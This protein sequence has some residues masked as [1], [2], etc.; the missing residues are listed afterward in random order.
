MYSNLHILSEFFNI[1]SLSFLPQANMWFCLI[2]ILPGIVDNFRIL[3]E[4][5]DP[6]ER[7]FITELEAPVK[8]IPSTESRWKQPASSYVTR[9][10]VFSTSSHVF[11]SAHE[12]KHRWWYN[13]MMRWWDV[14]LTMLAKVIYNCTSSHQ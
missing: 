10:L 11:S 1:L 8:T 7:T 13:E 4:T 14:E 6:Q 5:H 12:C 2:A 9:L 3:T